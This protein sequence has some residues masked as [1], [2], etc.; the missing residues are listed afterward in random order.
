MTA[1]AVRFWS[2]FSKNLKTIH[3]HCVELNFKMQLRFRNNLRFDPRTI[4]QLAADRTA[5][6]RG[7]KSVKLLSTYFAG[8]D[9]GWPKVCFAGIDR[10]RP[11]ESAKDWS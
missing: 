5:L 10:G 6:T 8:I 9:R 4:K 3:S 2:N 11:K 1:S 7:Q